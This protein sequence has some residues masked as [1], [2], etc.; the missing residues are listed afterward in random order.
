MFLVC[1]NVYYIKYIP[2]KSPNCVNI[3]RTDDDEDFLYLFFDNVDGD[4]EKNDGNKYLVFTPTEKNNKE[5]K[6]KSKLSNK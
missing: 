4:I 3:D 6:L 5:A 1:L 2:T